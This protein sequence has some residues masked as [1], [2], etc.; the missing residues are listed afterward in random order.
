MK[1]VQGC[2]KNIL[3]RVKVVNLSY[4]CC[5]INYDFLPV[6]YIIAMVHCINVSY[7]LSFYKYKMKYCK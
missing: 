6:L 7:C 4:K 2:G 5:K 3:D 1:I